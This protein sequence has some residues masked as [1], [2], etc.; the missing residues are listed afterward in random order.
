MQMMKF[1]FPRTTG[2]FIKSVAVIFVYIAGTV[3][4]LAAEKWNFSDQYSDGDE[5][6]KITLLGSL[7]IKPLDSKDRLSREIS[8]LAWD[9][10]EQILYGISD[11][12][13]I[14]HIR[15][16]ITNGI[17]VN[18]DVTHSYRLKDINGNIRKE[19]DADAE[20]LTLENSDNGKSGDS[21]LT[22][23]LDNNTR[24]QQYSNKGDFVR[25]IPLP[26]KFNAL[27]SKQGNIE[28]NSLSGN[29][30]D[31]YFF[32][33]REAMGDGFHYLFNTL[34]ISDRIKYE[35][36]AATNIVGAEHIDSNNLL[37][38]DRQYE[39]II[40]PV[41]YCLRSLNLT[42]KN[43][44]NIAC[45]NNKKGWKLDNFEGLARRGD[46][47]YFLISDD[48]ESILQKTLLIYFRCKECP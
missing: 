38:L 46:N 15:V 33:T 26:D 28:V 1:M 18:A 11:D 6:M 42:S 16:S 25:E 12:G 17:L 14:S 44:N 45:F 34:G 20:G 41:T 10:D 37:I 36:P 13:Y 3:H 39:S 29:S 23:V 43:M 22:V 7:Y 27:V 4:P 2:Y 47:N 5:F 19:K 8:G 24:L 32:I 31:G 30:R 40:K 9:E 48:N 21:L 35:N